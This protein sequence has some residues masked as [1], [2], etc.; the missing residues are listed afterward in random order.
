MKTVSFGLQPK[1]IQA[2]N[3]PAT[4]I[5]YG[6]AAGGGKSH[7]MRIAAMTWCMEIPGLQ[8][9]IFRRIF[10]DLVKNHVEG[11]TGF[12]NLL[13]PWVEAGKVEIVEHEIRFWNGS[14]IHLCHVQLE[15]HRF[16]YQG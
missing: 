14:K 3:S 12:R 16:K 15:K 5:L 4:E 8:V 13:Q 7:L 9:Y 6:G 1:Q 10:E 2:F 11:P